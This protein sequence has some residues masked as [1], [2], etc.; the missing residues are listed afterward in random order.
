M[1]SAMVVRVKLGGVHCD[2]VDKVLVQEV[3]AATMSV[4][5]YL[6]VT[7]ATIRGCGC[8]QVSSSTAV[9]Y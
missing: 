1:E 7:V 8:C 3:I 2:V 9:E 6:N 5:Q 4:I